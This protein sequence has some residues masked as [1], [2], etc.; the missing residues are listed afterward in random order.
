MTITPSMVRVRMFLAL[1]GRSLSCFLID[2]DFVVVAVS[3]V[4]PLLSVSFI[5]IFFIFLKIV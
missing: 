1:R 3:S 5:I 4:S 2:L